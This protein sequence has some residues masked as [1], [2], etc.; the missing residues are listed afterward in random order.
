[1]SHRRPR[2]SS[3]LG[4]NVEVRHRSWVAVVCVEGEVDSASV[5]RLRTAIDEAAIS[6][7]DVLI[8][9]SACPFVDSSALSQVLRGRQLALAQHVAFAAVC[10]DGSVPARVLDIVAAGAIPLYRSRAEALHAMRDAHPDANA[11]GAAGAAL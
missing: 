8:D 3:S 11:D 6:G 9:L 7:H 1:M 5:S 10:A 2:A 4:L